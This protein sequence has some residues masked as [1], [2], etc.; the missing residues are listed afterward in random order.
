VGRGRPP[1]IGR[2]E[3]FTSGGA[4]LRLGAKLFEVVGIVV[5]GRVYEE[6]GTIIITSIS[7]V[8]SGRC[9][10]QALSLRVKSFRAKLAVA[11]IPI[12]LICIT[13][14]ARLAGLKRILEVKRQGGERFRDYTP[15]RAI[16]SMDHG[17]TQTAFISCT[18]PEVWFG[19]DFSKERQEAISLARDSREEAL[20]ETS[21]LA[22]FPRSA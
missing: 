20:E 5:K 4:L 3:A 15:Q 22:P 18:E 6:Y 1:R 9:C 12:G 17:G 16:E 14:S 2:I 7:L 13:T 21:R 19:D 10:D 8:Q 11:V